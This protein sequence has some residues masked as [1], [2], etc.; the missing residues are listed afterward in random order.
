MEVKKRKVLLPNIL[1]KNNYFYSIQGLTVHFTYKIDNYFINRS[2]MLKD[3]G[4][5]S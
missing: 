2:K 3:L 5:Y 4:M 1:Y